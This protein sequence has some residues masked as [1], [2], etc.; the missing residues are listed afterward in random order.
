MSTVKYRNPSDTD[1]G[2]SPAIWGQIDVDHIR[3][4]PAFGVDF[5]DDFENFGTMTSADAT[6]KY[7][8]YADTGCSIV[9]LATEV[10]G[11]IRFD[12]DATG[13]DEECS[14][15]MGGNVAGFA[16]ITKDSGKKV[17]F[18]A[19]IRLSATTVQSMFIGMAEEALSGDGGANQA[20][21]TTGLCDDG[22]G[23]A[24][25]DKVGYR[26]L[27]ADADGLDAVHQEDA[28]T[29]QVVVKEEAQVVV[30]AAWYKVGWYFDGKNT[31]RFYVDGAEVGSCSADDT[32]F[33]DGQEL[34]L[35][36]G[37][38]QHE[39]AQKLLDMDWW[40]AAFER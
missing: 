25:K 24:D 31:I 12:C 19:R 21:D 4:D 27:E 13:S 1:I 37:I 10:G 35:F 6:Q 36:A 2:P 26:I 14:L 9:Q 28:G 32:D 5:F 3:D 8:G 20:A 38:K 39:A 16:K 34:A 22:T 17:A 29:A 15:T 30:A 33:P 7:L 23:L 11:V 40:R 18:E